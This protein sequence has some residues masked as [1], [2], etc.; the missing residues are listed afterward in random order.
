MPKVIV[1]VPQRPEFGNAYWALQRKFDTGAT[2]L[3]VSDAELAELQ[4]QPVIGVTLVSDLADAVAPAVV[5][6]AA[7][8][9][10]DTSKS[11]GKPAKR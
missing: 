3:D 10:S 8:D 4:G 5:D 7:V 6:A 2:V 11:P 1:T 9:A